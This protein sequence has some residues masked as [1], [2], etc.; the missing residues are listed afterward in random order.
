MINTILKLIGIVLLVTG[1]ILLYSSIDLPMYHN[2]TEFNEKYM[3]LNSG[4]SDSN[5]FYELREEYLTPKHKLED[6]GI[7]AII[8]GF[9]I[10][11]VSF[12]KVERIKS[13]KSWGGLLAVGILS[14]LITIFGYVGDLFLEMYRESYPHWAD[15][16]A[17]PI[18]GTPVLLMMALAWAII[19]LM[20]TKKNFSVNI[21]LLPIELKFTK[22]WFIIISSITVVAIIMTIVDGYF[23]QVGSGFM[24]L[25]FYL[26]IMQGFKNAKKKNFITEANRLA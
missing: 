13:P 20:G 18:M 17:I 9:V 16:L 8:V 10:I 12:I 22:K 15:S 24:W 26:S 11:I 23:W 14:A 2:A 3:E 1:G 19:N 4:E 5:K 7:T 6:Y 25:Y 21:S